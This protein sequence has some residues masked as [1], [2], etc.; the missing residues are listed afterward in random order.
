MPSRIFF[1]ISI[2]IIA[3][4]VQSSFPA[5]Y[6]DANMIE[7]NETNETIK[8]T[9]LIK[10]NAE[11]ILTINILGLNTTKRFAAGNDNI[12]LDPLLEVVVPPPKA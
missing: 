3:L 2:F 8:I 9:P 6:S 1:F 4:L 5:I 11:E 7:L 12:K 10:E